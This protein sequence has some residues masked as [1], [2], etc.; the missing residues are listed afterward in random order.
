MAEQQRDESLM[1]EVARGKPEA[2]G[3]LICRHATPL[4]TFLTRMRP[5]ARLHRVP[6]TE[7]KPGQRGPQ[8][9]W[10]AH[11]RAGRGCRP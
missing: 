1:A 2:L 3:P 9:R 4:L 8:P 7:C 5:D 11:R 10:V 6:P